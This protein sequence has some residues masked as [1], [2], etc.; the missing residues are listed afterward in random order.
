[1]TTIT[2]TNYFPT[3]NDACAYYKAQEGSLKAGIAAARQKM[4]EGEIIIGKPVL[5]PGQ[6]AF[7]KDHRWHVS[8]GVNVRI[9]RSFKVAIFTKYF[10]PSEVRGSRV[11]AYAGKGRYVTI[12]FD[13]ACTSEVA[14]EKAARALCEKMG[15]SGELLAGGIEDGGY[16]FVWM[17]H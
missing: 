14:H 1:M 7:V 13:H 17:N 15:W 3:Q 16:V 2:G 5:K 9:I 11:K 8:D 6:T 12:P 10:G 4:S